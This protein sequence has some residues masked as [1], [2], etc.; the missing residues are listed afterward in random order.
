MR[1]FVSS[2]VFD[3]I[4][5]RAE[6]EATL[7]DLGLTPVM[8]ER[9]TGFDVATDQ[10]SIE[11][12]LLNVEKADAVIVIL[13]KR[14]GPKLGKYGFDDISATHLE[15]RK[16]I[17]CQKPVYFFVR[18]RLE[19]DFNIHRKNNS[20][21]GLEYSWIPTGNDALFDLLDEHRRLEQ[22]ASRSNWVDLYTNS[23]DLKVVVKKRLSSVA[24]P[25]SLMRALEQNNFPLFDVSSESQLMNLQDKQRL[26]FTLNIKNIGNVPA[27][28]IKTNWALGSQE[29]AH[30]YELVGPGQTISATAIA[31][32]SIRDGV[33]SLH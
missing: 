1:I 10:N 24:K 31:P 30:E 3:L 22:D 13:N 27:Y 32:Q 25:I 33:M 28:R 8:S 14:Y 26:S 4:D 16:A 20:K 29:S 11:A 6:I 5:I 7:S 18:D 17:A 9:P 2:T 15:Y 23:I 21:V 12:C 19:A